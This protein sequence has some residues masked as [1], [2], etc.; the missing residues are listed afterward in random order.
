MDEQKQTLLT[1]IRLKQVITA[2]GLPRSTI[3]AR[4]KAGTFPRSVQLSVRSVG[5]RRGDIDLWLA[6]PAAYKAGE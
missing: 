6:N 5:W 1:V 4:M 3:Y 2:T